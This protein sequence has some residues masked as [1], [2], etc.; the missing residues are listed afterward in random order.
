VGF[1]LALRGLAAAGASPSRN[2][3]DKI[4]AVIAAWRQA[5][6]CRNEKE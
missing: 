2:A 4:L 6:P 1:D 5:S 3:A